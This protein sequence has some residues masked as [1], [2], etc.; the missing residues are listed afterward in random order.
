[1]ISMIKSLY[2]AKKAVM[3]EKDYQKGTYYLLESITSGIFFIVIG[4]LIIL[5]K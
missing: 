4:L 1:M 3:I 5:F 2:E